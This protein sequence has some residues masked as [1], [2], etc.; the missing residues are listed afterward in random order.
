MSV[1]NLDKLLKPGSLTLIGASRK[2]GSVGA[3]L[4]HNLF[5]A[6]FQ[7][8][9]MPVHPSAE[10]IQGVLAYH[11]VGDLP[12][13][14]DLAVIASPPDT[15]PGLV[16]ELGAR[17]TKAAVVITAG[18]GEGGRPEGLERRRAVLEAAR[19]HCLRVVGPN[20]L[21][22]M[23]PGVGLN[24][25]FSHIAPLAGNLAFVTQSGAIVTGMLDWAAPRGIGFSHVVSLGGMTDVDFGDLLDYL[26]MDAATGAVLLYVEAITQ[27]RKFMSAARAAARI[28]P[29][30]VVKGGRH[31]EGARAAASHT[32]ALA[33][34]DAVYEAA[35][36]RAGMLRVRTLTE[37]FDAAETLASMARTQLA[38]NRVAI[39]TNGGGLG[40]LATDALIDEGGC[41]AELGDGTLAAL[42]EAL[43]ATWN[44]G[45]PV[46]IIGDAPGERYKAALAALLE[47]PGSD[48]IPVLNCPTAVASSTDAARA[49]VDAL[50][51]GST[52]GHP[53][54]SRPVFT[55]WL[56]DGATREARRLFS[57]HHVPT[58]DTPEQAVR[59]ILHLV[60]YRRHQDMLMET[61]PALPADAKAEDGTGQE[62]A[63]TLVALAL[64]EGREWLSEPEAMALLAA[65]GVPVVA[66]RIAAT[67]EEAAAVAGEI[68]PPYVVKI[69]SPE[70][71]HKSDVGGV[72]LDLEG[73]AELRKAAA[74]MI[75]RVRAAQP[76]ARI[77]G[78]VVQSLCRRPG[79]EELICGLSVDPQFGPVIVFGQ[80]GTAVEVVRDMAL[81]LPPLN[82]KLARTMI[83]ETRVY[84]LLRGYRD[85][86]PADIDHIALTLIALSRL[87]A[88]FAEIVEVDINPL[89][90]DA[91]GVIALDARVRIAKATGRG[92]DRFA[93]RPYP[94]R[95]EQSLKLPGGEEIFLRPIRPEDEPVLQEGFKK[96]SREDVR[97]RFFAPL[98]ELHHPLAVRLT[99][100]DY[101]R[102]MALLALRGDGEAGREALGVVRIA[103]DPDN[104]QAE[105]AVTVRSDFKGR[106]LGR[107]LMERILAYA[108]IRG[109]GEI[110]GDV[111]SENE[112][113]RGLAVALGFTVEHL[114][115][116]P[117]IVRVRKRLEPSR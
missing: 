97:M 87:A 89:L 33:G 105:F 27:A 58:Y 19:P 86:P 100:I 84:R 26:A 85:R 96:L 71:V 78:F 91:H 109:I 13:T 1:R 74:A 41:L 49:V 57:E 21:G 77:K 59:A 107:V 5:N 7:G 54:P 117:S 48:A 31:E 20:C 40:V 102:E 28:K 73:P 3:V 95:L 52:S 10:A 2:A 45:N 111:L 9:V 51:G 110:W 25:S 47:D 44:R 56:G 64:D 50:A 34:A 90:V 93:I 67:P 94:A 55:A 88:D 104:L 113:M 116:E 23:V 36:A 72:V 43:P 8:P 83:E 114:P 60:C 101:D 66:T 63:R 98:R 61:P 15:V 76:E 17:G 46:D 108:E 6:G 79:A 62:A 65:Y 81:A 11:G 38:G 24:A 75:G 103:A 18:F 99:Q 68:E 42:D 70:I 30:I 12:V 22:I 115:D 80:G 32:G 14:P 112:A 16:A 53:S 92:E 4:A 69:L 29:V 35:F 37:L 82:M 106:G 39:L